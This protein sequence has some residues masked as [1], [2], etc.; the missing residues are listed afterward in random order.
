MG[1]STGSSG[2]RRV[3][4]VYGARLGLTPHESRV[5]RLATDGLTAMRRPARRL[6]DVAPAG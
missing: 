4:M 2:R 6:R 1:S 3:L 5:T